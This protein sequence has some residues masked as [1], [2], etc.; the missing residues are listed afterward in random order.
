MKKT[1]VGIVMKF[2]IQSISKALTVALA[3]SLDEKIW[4]DGSRTF[5]EVLLIH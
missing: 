2:S 3:F 5:Q 4:K 1:A